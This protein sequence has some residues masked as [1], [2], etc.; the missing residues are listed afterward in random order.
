MYVK[1][2]FQKPD[3]I[4]ATTSA[5]TSPGVTIASVVPSIYGKS[6]TLEALTDTVSISIG[7]GTAAYLVS[8]IVEL[9]HPPIGTD[10]YVLGSGTYQ[11]MA[12]SDND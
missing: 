10:I 7:S 1:Q 11:I 6:F 8:G 12:Y 9:T 3:V 4:L 2:T 5:A